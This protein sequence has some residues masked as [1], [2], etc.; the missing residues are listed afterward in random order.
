LEQRDPLMQQ[1]PNLKRLERLKR[2]E[3]T[4]RKLQAIIPI[5]ASM[6]MV[7]DMGFDEFTKNEEL[8]PRRLVYPFLEKNGVYWGFQLIAKPPFTNLSE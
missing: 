5:N 6:I 3:E 1:Y 7:D 2:T 8:R 4:G